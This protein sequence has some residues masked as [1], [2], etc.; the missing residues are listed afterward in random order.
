MCHPV[1]H[2]CHPLLLSYHILLSHSDDTLRYMLSTDWLDLSQA[3]TLVRC[4]T[5][6][7][8]SRAGPRLTAYGGVTGD[9]S[10]CS[11]VPILLALLLTT[12]LLT[13]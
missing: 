13:L 4:H 8:C 9:C 3:V 12:S 1:Q 10:S 2:S 11:A 7:H 6:S 5:E